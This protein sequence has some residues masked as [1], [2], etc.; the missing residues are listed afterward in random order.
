MYDPATDTWHIKSHMPSRKIGFGIAVYQ[1]KIYAIGGQSGY[2]MSGS[3]APIFS[4]SVEVYDPSTDTW[5]T[6]TSMPKPRTYLDAN[7]VND[8]IYL[9]GGSGGP[10]A[11]Q[12]YDPLT[13]TWTEIETHARASYP[14][15]YP[16]S[17]Y[18]YV[19]AVI[20]DKIYIIGGIY[21]KDSVQ[22]FDPRLQTWKSGADIPFYKSRSGCAA[23]TGK[24]APKRIYVLGGGDYFTTSR[25]EIYDP[26]SDTWTTGEPMPTSRH[27]LAVAVVDDK[28]YAIGGNTGYLGTVT[29]VN[30]QY[31]PAGYIPEFPAWLVLPLFLAA[32]SVV[33]FYR[34]RMRGRLHISS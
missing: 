10:Y 29:G 31:T 8:K 30:E 13:D 26:E 12:V 19:S 32:T 1:D 3:G 5:E 7:V 16:L 25:N 17:V 33:I 23:T 2:N 21:G 22:I 18:L 34:K 28:I 14:Y 9:I 27:D 11:N 4:P 6:K 20:D 24:K 15:S